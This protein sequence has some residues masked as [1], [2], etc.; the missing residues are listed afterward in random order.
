LR[1]RRLAEIEQE[2]VRRA[3]Y[4]VSGRQS[5]SRSA[6]PCASLWRAASRCAGQAPQ[7]IALLE[8]KFADCE[9]VRAGALRREIAAVAP[10]GS[11]RV[12]EF[13]VKIN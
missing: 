10:H 2:G 6:A 4:A 5:T 11:R 13:S 1:N 3:G 12:L 7:A 9:E 8:G